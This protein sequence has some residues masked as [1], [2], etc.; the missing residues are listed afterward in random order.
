MQT[1][2][3][4]GRRG[5]DGQQNLP[6]QRF[7]ARG[8]NQ[9]GGETRVVGPGVRDGESLVGKRTPPLRDRAMVD[10][11]R[12]PSVHGPGGRSGGRHPRTPGTGPARCEPTCPANEPL[13]PRPPPAG[14]S[15]ARCSSG[16]AGA[17]APPPHDLRRPER[18]TPWYHAR[19]PGPTGPWTTW[20]GCTQCLSQRWGAPSPM[21]PTGLAP[22]RRAPARSGG[23][24][25][26][27]GPMS[28]GAPSVPAAV[29][30]IG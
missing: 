25:A 30:T 21:R 5:A 28:T 19:A 6:R 27:G 12:W 24:E 2:H 14:D 15:P 4:R 29:F 3:R 10:R 23:T 26:G 13:S 7:A 17:R 1:E 8:T 20:P 18:H 11:A 9:R 22:G 16:P